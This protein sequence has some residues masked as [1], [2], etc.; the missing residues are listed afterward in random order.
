[1][2]ANISLPFLGNLYLYHV[3]MGVFFCVINTVI[4]ATSGYPLMSPAGVAFWFK[5]LFWDVLVL[6][7]VWWA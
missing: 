4:S 5:M 3:W 6:D 1:M 7:V 2:I